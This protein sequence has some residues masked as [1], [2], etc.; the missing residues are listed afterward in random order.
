MGACV[1]CDAVCPV[2]FSPRDHNKQT[3]RYQAVVLERATANPGLPDHV[4]AIITASLVHLDL[5]VNGELLQQLL[6]RTPRRNMSAGILADLT[7]ALKKLED[8]GASALLQQQEE[9]QQKQDALPL[10]EQQQRQQQQEQ[11]QQQR[12]QQHVQQQQQR[13]A[14]QSD[15]GSVGGGVNAGDSL[16]GDIDSLVDSARL[17]LVAARGGAAKHPGGTAEPDSDG[18]VPLS[19]ARN[20]PAAVTA[21][22]RAAAAADGGGDGGGYGDSEFSWD[23]YDEDEDDML[24]DEAT[25]KRLIA[26]MAAVEELMWESGGG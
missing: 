25:K 12:Y 18:F 22:P 23:V 11:R 8:G 20:K 17:R 19:V 6:F 3:N 7:A 15:S 13:V 10:W 24:I 21:K 26:R 2:L 5:P 16:D 1:L 14:A 4:C 9:Q